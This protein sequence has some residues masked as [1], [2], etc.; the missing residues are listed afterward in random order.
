[1]IESVGIKS[2]YKPSKEALTFSLAASQD[3][4]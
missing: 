1:M 3:S 4:S 2:S